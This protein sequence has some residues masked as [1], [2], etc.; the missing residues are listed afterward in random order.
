MGVSAV[1]YRIETP[2]LVLRCWEPDDAPLLKDAVDSSLEHLRPWMPWAWFE[3]Q[4]LDEK[5]ELLRTFRGRF[6]LGTDFVYG[7]FEAD[8]SRALGGSGLHPRGGEGSLEIG[9]WIRADSIER[10]LATEVAGVLTRVGFE[11]FG[12]D[13]VDLSVDPENERSAKIPRKLGFVEEGR[14]RRRLPPK[15]EGGQR[16]DQL[17]FSLLA[18]ELAA[19]PCL[20]FEYVAFD[21]LGREL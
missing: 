11:H 21:A 14:L 15:T 16:R 19:S 3:P 8:D 18:E 13:R 10:G 7:I 9:Y 2:R 1:A 5:L 12:L 4:S 20:E 6:D 17:M